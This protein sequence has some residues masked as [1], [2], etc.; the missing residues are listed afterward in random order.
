M[1]DAYS[2]L[3]EMFWCIAFLGIDPEADSCEADLHQIL[4]GYCHGDSSL[5]VQ[6]DSVPRKKRKTILGQSGW[7]TVHR[8]RHHYHYHYQSALAITELSV[9]VFYFRL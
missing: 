7:L 9:S 4:I 2:R 5:S 3:L 8:Q 1:A 6:P